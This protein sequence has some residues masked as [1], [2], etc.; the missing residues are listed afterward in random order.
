[1]NAVLYKTS[2]IFDGY[3]ML[4]TILLVLF[5]HNIGNGLQTCASQ[6]IIN[7]SWGHSMAW[8]SDCMVKVSGIF[9]FFQ[10]KI[11]CHVSAI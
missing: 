3:D 9:I 4:S 6:V 1:M 10:N 11:L 5:I 2:A 7:D 8:I